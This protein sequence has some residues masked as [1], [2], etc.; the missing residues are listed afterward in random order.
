MEGNVRPSRGTLIVANHV[1]SPDIFVLGFC[2]GT[3]FLS[4][5]DVANWPIVGTLARLGLTVFVDRSRKHQVK[6]NIEDM[7]RRL[8]EGDSIV[9]FAEGGASDGSD[10]L[11]FKTSFFE[12]AVISRSPVLP[13]AISYLDPGRPSVACWRNTT[14]ATHFFNLL[15][16]PQLEAEVGVLPEIPSEVGR[17]ELAKKSRSSIQFFLQRKSIC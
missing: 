7:A 9:L 3:F 15:S 2:F 5:H 16:H 4:K 13:I 12:A 8:G 17:K 1:G 11:P 10:V 6:A 14:F